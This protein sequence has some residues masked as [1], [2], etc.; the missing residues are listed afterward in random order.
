M[1]HAQICPTC[2]LAQPPD[3][4]PLAY[5]AMSR[6]EPPAADD[7]AVLYEDTFKV[8]HF[9]GAL[10]QAAPQA[11]AQAGDDVSQDDLV[12]W[13]AWLAEELT[14]E[15]ARR[16]RRVLTAGQMRKDSATA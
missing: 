13:L 12:M 3:R 10:A 7:V 11:V 5:F 8:L 14:E 16:L 4:E 6:K 1:A 9:L 2:L 15:A